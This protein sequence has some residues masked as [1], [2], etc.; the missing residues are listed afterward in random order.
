MTGCKVMD[1]TTTEFRTTTTALQRAFRRIRAVFS[2]PSLPHLVPPLPFPCLA[3]F[4]YSSIAYHHRNVLPLG[5]PSTCPYSSPGNST[6][7]QAAPGTL[8][9]PGNWPLSSPAIY[10]NP[11][12]LL[13]RLRHLSRSGVASFRFPSA[14][15]IFPASRDAFS[16]HVPASRNQLLHGL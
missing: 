6:C 5:H 7:N 11:I 4:L 9:K 10:L 3:A 12:V 13:P 15:V 16:F 2:T 14:T 1:T 8:N